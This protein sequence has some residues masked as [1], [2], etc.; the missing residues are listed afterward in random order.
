MGVFVN[1]IAIKGE[2]EFHILEAEE[3]EE[4]AKEISLKRRCPVLSAYIY[5]GDYWGYTLY[6]SGEIQNEFATMPD[7]FEDSEEVVFRY[8]ANVPLLSQSFAVS[9]KRIERYLCH[10][11]DAMLEGEDFAYEEDEFPY[12]D[13]WQMVDFLKTLGFQYPEDNAKINGIKRMHVVE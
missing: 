4:T 11:T 13:A 7:Y 8:A 10:W 1:G 3:A 5:D 12:G 2:G 9:A 6:L